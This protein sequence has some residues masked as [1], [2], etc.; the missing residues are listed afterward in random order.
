[1]TNFSSPPDDLAL[2]RFGIIAPLLHRHDDSGPLYRELCVLSQRTYYTATGQEKQLCADTLRLW[3][4]RYKNMG[5]AGLRNKERK[6]RCATKVPQPLRDALVQL[7]T[8]HPLYTVKRL[9]GEL[10]QKGVWDGRTPSRTALYRFTA[11][12]GLNR[13]VVAVVAGRGLK[14]LG[15]FGQHKKRRAHNLRCKPLL[16]KVPPHRIELWTQGFSVL[17][18]TD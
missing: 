8:D 12:R 14:T 4:G 3:L 15:N 7:R 11:S 13:N 1:M 9:L 17:C 10:L 5:L 18:S 16:L 2:W 6:D